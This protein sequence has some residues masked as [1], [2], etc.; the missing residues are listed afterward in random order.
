M[1]WY[2]DNGVRAWWSLS[3]DWPGSDI[4]SV[5][6]RTGE[7]CAATCRNRGGCRKFTYN[8]DTQICWL[9]DG[10]DLVNTGT[11]S[12]VCGVLD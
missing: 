10:G 6:M 7:R 4:G 1:G 9:K 3:C 11:D 8:S 2:R 5:W 12:T